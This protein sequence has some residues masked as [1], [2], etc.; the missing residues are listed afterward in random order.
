MSAFLKDLSGFIREQGF[1]V[2]RIAEMKDG[3]PPESLTLTP[4]NPCQN[5]YSVAKAFTVTAVGLLY[6]DGK[7][8]VSEKVTGILRAEF[9]A[10]G[11][12]R[13]HT[14]TVDHAL[15]HSLGLP[16]GFL[17]IDVCDPTA[18]GRDYLTYLF[19]APPDCAP[20]TR[21]CYTDGAYYLLSRIVEKKAGMP[22]DLFL[23]QRLFFDLGFYEVAW[24]RCPM[25]HAMGATG[26]YIR[27]Q[28]MVKLG[29]LYRTGGTYRG[30]RLLSEDWVRKTLSAPYE[31]SYNEGGRSFSKGG[32]CGQNLL[33]VPAQN[34][35][36]AW[37][38]YEGVDNGV[39]TRWI[40]N[41]EG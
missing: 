6:D 39:L 26:L 36:V 2:L 27:A 16:G 24:S 7:L 13:W 11:D 32:M 38:S 30:K 1:R 14:A 22:L 35:A 15:R 31:L 34:R 19:R 41:Y 3:A 8:D 5:S 23:W 17:D 28:D 40:E 29:E 20:G 10:D 4:C 37:H 33:V 9:P 18:F 25:G 12:E 21:R